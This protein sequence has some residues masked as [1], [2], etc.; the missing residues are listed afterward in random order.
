[1]SHRRLVFLQA[2]VARPELQQRKDRFPPPCSVPTE[3][4]LS[5]PAAACPANQLATI[6]ANNPNTHKTTTL[7][8]K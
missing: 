2:L 8:V 4:I 1:M 6:S 3:T 5:T 7:G